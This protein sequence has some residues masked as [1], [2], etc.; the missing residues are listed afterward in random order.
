MG[1]DRLSVFNIGGPPLKMERQSASIK[2]VV[3]ILAH[4]SPVP[5]SDHI[6]P[7]N[8]NFVRKP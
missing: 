8:L 7:E 3:P 4:L 2:E 6:T 1:Y 5:T